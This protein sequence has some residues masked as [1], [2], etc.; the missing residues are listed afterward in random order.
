MA[1]TEAEAAYLAALKERREKLA[2]LI[3]QQKGYRLPPINIELQDH[4]RPP[5]GDDWVGWLLRAGRRAGKSFACAAFTADYVRKVSPEIGRMR[6]IA[7]TFADAVESCVKGPSGLLALD[8][9]VTWHPSA[10]GGAVLRWPNKAEMLVLG[11]NA[12]GDVDRLRATG[13]RSLDWFEEAAANKQLKDA[14]HQAE[15][16]RNLGRR[17]WIGSTTPRPLEILKEWEAD[18]KVIVT[19]A[20]THDNKHLTQAYLDDME[21]RL[22][23]TRLYRQE[24]LG[25]ILEDVEGALWKLSDIERSVVKSGD[26][27]DLVKII[28]GVDPPA[29]PGTCGIVVVGID[30]RDH[31]YVLDDY[32][33]TDVNPHEWAGA[34]VQAAKDYGALVVAEKNQGYRMVSETLKAV[35]PGM[36]VQMVWASEGKKARAEPISILWEADEQVAHMQAGADLDKLIDEMT[37]WVPGTFSPDR[38]DAMVWA[39]TKLRESAGFVGRVSNPASRGS[40]PRRATDGRHGLTIAR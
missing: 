6:L 29:G 11:T 8:H 5:E 14:F 2:A 12:P 33:M 32:S 39:A 38:L 10:P 21:R 1:L 27:P 19:H 36:P 16:G 40:I 31:I 26:I 20:I 3:E 30:R 13:G 24:I 35:A 4:Q 34:V 23:G 28:V 37:G 15:L 25:E 7:P 18:P 17:L 9:S 22:K